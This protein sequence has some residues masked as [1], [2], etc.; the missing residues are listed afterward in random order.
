MEE[1]W[2]ASLGYHGNGMHAADWLSLTTA[3]QREATNILTEQSTPPK[4]TQV[5]SRYYGNYNYPIEEF[6][7]S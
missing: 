5:L 2:N 7:S 1:W 6:S 4:K 3:V